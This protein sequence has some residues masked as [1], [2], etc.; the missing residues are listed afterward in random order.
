MDPKT[1]DQSKTNNRRPNNEANKSEFDEQTLSIDRVARVVKGGRRFRFRALVAV[2]DHKG[3]VGVGSSKGSDVTSAITKASNVAKKNLVK[4]VNYKQT[5][6]HDSYAKVGGAK[7]KIMPASQG[8]GVIAG[9][10]TR[11]IVELAGIENILSKSIG[12]SNKT[13]VA[14]A[15]I[16]ALQKLVNPKDWTLEVKPTHL[17]TEVVKNE[18][19][20]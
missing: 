16:E 14:Y 11:T 12:T 15:T 18:V 2:G 4:I 17:K 3:Q 19:K 5:I 7:V 10:V 8:T 13:N 6:P 20:S 1:T 9:G